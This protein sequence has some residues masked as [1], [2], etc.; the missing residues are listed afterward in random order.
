MSFSQVI[1]VGNIGSLS[2]VEAAGVMTVKLSVSQSA[3]GGQAA[4]FAK[5]SAS[6]ELDLESA[7]IVLMALEFI[8]SK[9]PPSMQPLV[10]ALEAVAIPAIK[11][12]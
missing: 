10:T 7:Q 5:G 4:G 2:I 3:G 1:P 11:A 8:K 9:L 12:A 6:V